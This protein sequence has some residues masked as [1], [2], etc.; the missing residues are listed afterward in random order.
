MGLPENLRSSA[1][2]E[3]GPLLENLTDWLDIGQAAL[4]QPHMGDFMIG[5]PSS[6]SNAVN[7]LKAGVTTIG[8]LSQFFSHEAPGWK[9]VTYTTV[10]TIKATLSVFIQYFKFSS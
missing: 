4:I 6:T 10:E 2:A 8:N 5:F 3:T 9:D 7:A 1:P